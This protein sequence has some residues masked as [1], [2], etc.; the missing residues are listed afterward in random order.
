MGTCKNCLRKA[1]LTKTHNRCIKGKKLGKN[2]PL[3]I[4]LTFPYPQVHVCMMFFAASSIIT[5]WHCHGKTCFMTYRDIST[6]TWVQSDTPAFI[7]WLAQE[8]LFVLCL[9]QEITGCVDMQGSLV[10]QHHAIRLSQKFS[11][12]SWYQH[13]NAH[14][15]CYLIN[16]QDPHDMRTFSDML[17]NI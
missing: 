17:L 13:K 7:P 4:S 14:S 10:K 8:A 1:I 2:V 15:S 11:L 12:R 9:M 5:M 16:H 3:L 6:E